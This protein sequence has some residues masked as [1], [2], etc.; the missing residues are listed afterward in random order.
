[1]VARNPRKSPTTLDDN[2]GSSHRAVGHTG[3]NPRQGCERCWPPA[4]VPSA[5]QKPPQGCVGKW[6]GAVAA[7]V[8]AEGHIVARAPQAWKESSARP[9]DR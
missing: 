2:A 9:L 8:A 4:G 3:K 1:M 5:T 6:S 7:A